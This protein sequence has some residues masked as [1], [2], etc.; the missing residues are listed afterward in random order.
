MFNSKLNKILGK[1]LKS[2]S[3]LLRE[4]EFLSII[5]YFV[6][7]F[8]LDYSG[9]IDLYGQNFIRRL[10]NMYRRKDELTYKNKLKPFCE[11]SP[12]MLT[13]EEIQQLQSIRIPETTD[14]SIFTRHNTTTHQ[15]CDKFNENEKQI[16]HEISEKV[17]Q[18]Y[19]KKIGKKLYYLGNN[20]ATIYVYHGKYS[21][22]LW[23]VDP[24]NLREVYNVIICIRKKGEISPLQCKNEK[25]DVNSIH[26]KRETQH[27][28]MVE[29][30]CTR[31][32]Q[33]MMII[34]KELFYQLHM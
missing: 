32:L 14:V 24:Q 34:Q 19:E 17:K 27:Y 3:S 2:S 12:K 23:H 7:M 11:P 8:S 30:Q 13:K 15:C 1:Y 20:K 9:A 21:Q 5:V 33:I 31:Y 6:L 25:G 28:L 18:R 10:I 26:L 4:N 22:H 16:I 29:Q